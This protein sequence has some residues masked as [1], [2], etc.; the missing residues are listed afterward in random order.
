MSQEQSAWLA[1]VIETTEKQ[2]ED[3]LFIYGESFSNS[4]GVAGLITSYTDL[5]DHPLIHRCLK[6]AVTKNAT[7]SLKLIATYVTEPMPTH[8]ER[9]LIQF[10][11]DQEHELYRL[12]PGIL[13]KANSAP[14]TNREIVK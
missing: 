1:P 2:I 14:E 5:A 3:L 6:Q 7:W 13:P 11:Y 12:N 10:A 8:N 4:I 9:S